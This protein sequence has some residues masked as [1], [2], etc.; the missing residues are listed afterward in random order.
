VL[1]VLL[2]IS[3]ALCIVPLYLVLY[4]IPVRRLGGFL[5]TILFLNYKNKRPQLVFA[6]N[7]LF[8]GPEERESPTSIP[9]PVN[10]NLRNKPSN[11]SPDPG[12]PSSLTL[13]SAPNKNNTLTSSVTKE[14]PGTGSKSSSKIGRLT[15]PVRRFTQ[16]QV[17]E[18]EI[19]QEMTPLSKS[20]S[21]DSLDSIKEPEYLV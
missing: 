10:P 2:I 7:L 6:G 18:V 19:H 1:A 5:A 11:I 13:K 9:Q 16:R 8:S 14:G 3:V 20:L 4:C 15:D 21:G 12:A 17:V